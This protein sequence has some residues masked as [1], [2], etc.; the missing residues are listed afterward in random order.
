M[1]VGEEIRAAHKRDFLEFLEQDVGKGI[2]M[3]EIKAMINHKRHCLIINISDLLSITFL[4]DWKFTVLLLDQK[5]SKVFISAPQLGVLP[6][7]NTVTLHP[8]WACPLDLCI[9]QGMKMATC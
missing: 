4:F 2:Y 6:A 7:M 1:D 3:D 9:P 5:L 8:T